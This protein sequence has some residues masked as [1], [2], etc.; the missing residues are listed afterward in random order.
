[1]FLLKLKFSECRQLVEARNQLQAASQRPARSQEVFQSA[2]E[3]EVYE[4]GELGTDRR[5]HPRGGQKYQEQLFKAY[6]QKTLER[7]RLLLSTRAQERR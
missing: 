4:R 2:R 1:M 7:W 6:H 3:A 5:N